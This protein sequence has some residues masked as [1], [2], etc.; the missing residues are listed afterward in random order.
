MS[1]SNELFWLWLSAINDVDPASR[2]ALFQAVPSPE[3]F[4][5]LSEKEYCAIEGISRKAAKNL[6]NKNLEDA[7]RAKEFCE[8]RGIQV[9]PFDSPLYPAR[10]KA[11]YA[12]PAVIYIKG[13]L[14]LVDENAVISVIGTRKASEYGIRMGRSIGYEIARCGGIVVSGLTAGVDAAA[15]EGAIEGGTCIGVL[16]TSIELARSPLAEKVSRQGALVS[17]Y[18][19]GTPTQ[20]AFFRARNRIAAGLSLGVVVVEA[21]EKSGTRLFV[22]E[23]LDQGKDIF[24]LPGNVDSENSAGTLRLLKEG[25]QLVSHGWEV[26]EEYQSRY[27]DKIDTDIHDTLLLQQKP[28]K[29][30]ARKISKK[31][32]EWK[33]K[34]EAIPPPE[35]KKEENK[36]S[37]LMPD[38][39]TEP[40]QQIV[41]AIQNQCR[42]IDGIINETGLPAGQVLSQLTML[43]IRGIIRRE[44]A[45]GIEL[46]I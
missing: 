33:R 28:E 26:L 20:R 19:P 36:N 10:L 21:P 5:R 3:A 39:L 24:A 46:K 29:A 8:N 44:R 22:N 7:I 2:A 37:F 40:Q 42:C 4:F 1:Q 12:P 11:I 41:K 30:P 43:E 9:L 32:A 6:A 35:P 34:A 31:K 16:G 25:A 13:K 38:N 27:P 45:N 15:A 18:A 17:E 23:A 14:P